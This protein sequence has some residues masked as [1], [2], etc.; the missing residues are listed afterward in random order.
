MDNINLIRR[1]AWSFYKT[2]KINGAGKSIEWGDLFGEACL[3][4]L[5]AIQSYKPGDAKETTFA[6]QAMKNRLITF[7]NKEL[8]YQFLLQK[9][10]GVFNWADL[11]AETPEYEFFERSFTS[12]PRS[13][14]FKAFSQDTRTIIN[15]VLREPQKY[16][17]PPRTVLG[18]IRKRLQGKGWGESRINESIRVL[19]KE[20]S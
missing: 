10:K 12:L 20:L 8:K 17:V 14:V 1:I 11:I 3:A 19:K 16:A 2:S 18:K 4:Y 7:C 13:D 5:K 9:D 6:Y 15:L